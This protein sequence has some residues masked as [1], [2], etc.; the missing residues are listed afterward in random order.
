MKQDAKE[1]IGPRGTVQGFRPLIREER[2]HKDSFTAEMLE[3]GWRPMLDDEVGGGE[4]YHEDNG[5]LK[6]IRVQEQV[7]AS[8]RCNH[9][10]TKRPLPPPQV[11]TFEAHGHVWYRHVPGDACPVEADVDVDYLLGH[12]LMS[13]SGFQPLR[14]LSGKLSWGTNDPIIGYRFPDFAALHI[15][16]Q[17]EQAAVTPVGPMKVVEVT[18]ATKKQLLNM[19]HGW[20]DVAPDSV[21]ECIAVVA[22]VLYPTDAERCDAAFEAWKKQ[23]LGVYAD[24]EWTTKVAWDAA[25]SAAKQEKP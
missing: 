1:T 3:G 18:D 17:Q 15:P 20:C 11:E 7:P 9:C 21:A 12:E 25:W 6:M 13:G 16:L 19:Y 10:R 8:K 22:R 4:I 5:W 23:A 24:P 2:W 14:V